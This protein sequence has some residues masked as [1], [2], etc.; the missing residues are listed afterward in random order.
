MAVVDPLAFHLREKV[1]NNELSKREI[2]VLKLVAEGMSNKDIC[3]QFWLSPNTVGR[4]MKN[5]FRKL[6][7]KNRTQA[8]LWAWRNGLMD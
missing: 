7:V 1:V 3:A 6:G 2:E 4:H 5:I 8:A